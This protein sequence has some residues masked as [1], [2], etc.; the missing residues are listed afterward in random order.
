[1]AAG[2]CAALAIVVLAAV[3][4]HRPA[5]DY[6]HRPIAA[7]SK[8]NLAVV[9]SKQSAGVESAKVAPLRKPALV[10]ARRKASRRMRRQ[11]KEPEIIVEPG[12]MQAL[13]QFVADVQKGKIDGAKIMDEIKAS[14]KPIE[15]K[16][17]T[18]TPLDT[19]AGDKTEEPAASVK[20]Q[21]FANA[22]SN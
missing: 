18:I 14:Q 11:A 3:A 12:Q 19:S 9:P 22:R 5:R 17:L 8:P 21:N 10:V 1:M 2:A 16:P 6:A 20:D 15:I 13:M 7:M 4:L